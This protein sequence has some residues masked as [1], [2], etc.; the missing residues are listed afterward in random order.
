MSYGCLWA[1]IIFDFGNNK[2]IRGRQ[3]V[4]KGNLSIRIF[5]FLSEVFFRISMYLF[6]KK[7][8][9][10]LFSLWSWSR[11][12]L[13]FVFII[14][15]TELIIGF[16][17]KTS[18]SGWLLKIVSS[19]VVPDLGNPIKK[20]GLFSFIFDVWLSIKKVLLSKFLRYVCM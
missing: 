11:E 7:S 1:N 3:T 15:S 18:I 19:K 5:A 16:S 13:N 14:C 20:T 2:F 17:S 6:L 12:H 10:F 9:S 8:R 4:W